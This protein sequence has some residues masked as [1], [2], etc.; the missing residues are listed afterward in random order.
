[1]SI[2]DA[3]CRDPE[4]G[5]LL[6]QE[7]E[8][9]TSMATYTYS[10]PP[11]G[12]APPTLPFPTYGATFRLPR[13]SGIRASFQPVDVVKWIAGQVTLFKAPGDAVSFDF[14]GCIMARFLLNG[15]PYAAHIHTAEPGSKA[16]DQRL[17]WAQFVNRYG[18][19][20]LVMF[21]P[22]AEEFEQH[23]P[24]RNTL[25]WGVITPA[26]QCYA[27][28]ATD[29]ATGKEP[30]GLY[31]VHKIVHYPRMGCDRRFYDPL[32]GM[33]QNAPFNEVSATWNRFWRQTQQS[34][35][36]IYP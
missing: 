24:S 29:E 14:G 7:N 23:G 31:Q 15:T 13:S 8:K 22:G 21:Q 26:Q 11:A 20:D 32:L 2:I 27:I 18:I 10:R 34:I 30:I 5:N 9:C 4:V 16:S 3:I 1:M 19:R 28:Y 17:A 33:P 25:I 36:T 12:A 6:G 35:T